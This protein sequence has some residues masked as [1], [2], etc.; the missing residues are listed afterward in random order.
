M[1]TVKIINV[2]CV[3]VA[4]II[5][6]LVFLSSHMQGYY[7]KQLDDYEKDPYTLLSKKQLWANISQ[8]SLLMCAFYSSIIG[9]FITLFLKW[10]L[11]KSC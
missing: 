4:C 5:I 9:F 7:K 1:K 11:K 3:I 6:L 2:L 10:I 8:S